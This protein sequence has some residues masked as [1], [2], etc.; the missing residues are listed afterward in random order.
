[1]YK[2]LST[3]LLSLMMVEPGPAAGSINFLAYPVLEVGG[4]PVKAGVEFSF[5]RSADS[6][7]NAG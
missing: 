1:M 4:Q 6:G 2:I 3:T 5:T 7:N